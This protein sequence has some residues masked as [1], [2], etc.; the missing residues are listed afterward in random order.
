MMRTKRKLLL[1]T[2]ESKHF[3]LRPCLG[4]YKVCYRLYGLNKVGQTEKVRKD[5]MG[6][7]SRFL[8]KRSLVLCPDTLGHLPSYL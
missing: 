8:G 5:R 3:L 2:P 1:H 4:V 6:S 7:S